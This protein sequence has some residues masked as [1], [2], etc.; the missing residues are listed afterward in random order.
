MLELSPKSVQINDAF[1]SA[2]L[3]VNARQAIFHQWH[4][5]EASGCIDNFRIAAGEKEGM[6]E[7]WFFADSDATKWLDAAAR[8]ERNRHDEALSRLMDDF[9]KLLEKVQSEDGYLF[10]YN[11][12]HFPGQ[13]WVNLQI[14]HEL[15]CHGHLIEAGVSHFE[16]TAQSRLLAVARKAADL[17][18]RDFLH[19]GPEFIPGH[20][21]IEIALLRLYSVTGEE[22]YRDLARHFIEARGRKLFFG[23]SLIGQFA[24]NAK[25]EKQVSERHRR[26]FAEREEPEPH[27]VPAMNRAVEPPF[28]NLRFFASGLNGKYFQQHRPIRQQ[29]VPV[30]HAVR[31]GYLNTA[32]AMLARSQPEAE[33][34]HT[35][36]ENWEHMVTRRMDVS[37][38]LGALPV[39]EAFG[40]DYELNPEVAYNETCAAVASLLW[41]WQ[42]LLLTRQA[43]Y[44]DLCEWQLYNAVSVGMGTDGQ[45][46]FYNNPTL[47]RG[48]IDRKPWY[49]I[50]CCPSNLS[51]TF[52]DLGKYVATAD[53]HEIWL[54]QYIGGEVSFDQS[55]GLRITIESELPWQGRVK[56]RFH[57]P[58]AKRFTLHLRL[59]SWTGGCKLQLNGEEQE[60]PLYRKVKA[61]PTACGY[62]P[63]LAFD[64]PID[65]EWQ[66][67]DE[68]KLE[69]DLPV[70]VL[71]PHERVRALRG[72]VA[73]ARGPLLYCLE[74][75]DQPELNILA[76][77]LRADQLSA[78]EA[79]TS[80]GKI[81]LVKAKTQSGRE[82]TFIPYFLWGNR[83]NSQ[84]TA[85]IKQ[86]SE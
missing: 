4:M 28:S 58:E 52:A 45:H 75:V 2:R 53:S 55:D 33:L 11:Q 47:C 70:R 13:R 61:D 56:A 42:M 29:K 5:L 67:G 84:M 36:E 69:L 31:M 1:W 63:R 78:Q 60:L 41:S 15:Y 14:E 71:H 80:L 26:Y 73:I 22:S 39:S 27:P 23:L 74:S 82:L 66:D 86:E 46:Y 34:I 81:M 77:S 68:I 64:L 8:I 12:I 19:A 85:W 83:G 9:I 10:T 37:G 25:R 30:G 32:A 21:E 51:R 7:G 17:L 16:A 49:S 3:E 24:S 38:G 57:L 65:R 62:D 48:G 20:E 44:A 76:E 59:P 50:P 6:R 72:K 40:R 18:V 79:E 35:L 43:R 54:H